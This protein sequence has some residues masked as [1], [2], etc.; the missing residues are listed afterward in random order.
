MSRPGE[1]LTTGF[2]P[3]STVAVLPQVF[4]HQPHVFKV[5]DAGL[6]MPEPKT[7]RML[8]HQRPRLL[9]Q[10]RR[11]GRRGGE[12]VHGFRPVILGSMLSVFQR[13]R[14][15]GWQMKRSRR[16]S[17]ERMTVDYWRVVAGMVVF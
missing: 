4:D 13:N 8:P 11:R 14:K 6:R 12:I 9:N 5:P 16:R 3:R 15:S 17:P 7:F 10:L 1:R 2:P